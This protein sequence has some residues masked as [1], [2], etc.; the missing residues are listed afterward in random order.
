DRLSSLPQSP[1]LLATRALLRGGGWTSRLLTACFMPLPRPGPAGL[2]GQ[3]V[4]PLRLAFP[5]V[6]LLIHAIR[7][8]ST[9]RR[10]LSFSC[11]QPASPARPF[12]RNSLPPPRSSGAPL[13]N[14]TT[15]RRRD[16]HSRSRR[17]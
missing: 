13:V 6:L 7:A 8:N 10:R 5:L 11:F 9:S 1:P 15:Q 14:D 3:P 16:Q 2:C 12:R 17:T 4:L